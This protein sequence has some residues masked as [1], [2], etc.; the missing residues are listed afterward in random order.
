LTFVR[1]DRTSRKAGT[2]RTKHGAGSPYAAALGYADPGIPCGL[3]V[4]WF[5]SD[6]SADQAIY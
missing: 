4:E 5:K 2:E 3:T 1:W 6:I